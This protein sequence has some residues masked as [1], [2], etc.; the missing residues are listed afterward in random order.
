MTGYIVRRLL[1]MVPLLW[2]VATFTFLLMHAIPG[3]PFDPGDDQR[4]AAITERLERKYGLD[5]PLPQQ[6]V[7]FLGSLVRGDLGISFQRGRPVTD[8]LSDGMPDTVQLGLTAFVFALSTGVTLGVVAATRQGGPLDHLSVLLATTG[9]AVPSFVVAVFLVVV[10]A[11]KLGWFDVIGW[12]FGNPRKMVLPVVALG[13]FPASFIARITRASMLEVLRH[14]YIRTARAKGLPEFRIVLR[15]ALRN[16]LVPV[17]TVSGPILAT[18]ITGS[19]VVERTFAISGIG[20]A[21]VDA[22]FARDYGLIM[23]TTLL[24]AAVIIIANLAVDIAYGVLDPRIRV[25]S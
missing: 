22:V 23:G 15:H 10:F 17:L 3:S 14:D 11:L 2:A 16:A 24:Y 6:Y 19:F 20:T 25:A 12:E 4:A 18:L 8:V 9:A 5:K 7:T 21:Y 1:L 13:L